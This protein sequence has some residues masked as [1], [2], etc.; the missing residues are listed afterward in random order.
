MTNPDDETVRRLL[1]STRHI[2]VVGLSPNPMRDSH[3]ITA[4]MQRQGYRVTGVNPGHAT[5]LGEPCVPTLADIARLPGDPRPLDLV[6]FFRRSSEVGRHMDEAVALGAR[7]LWLQLGVVDEAAAER[8]RAAGVV[9]VMDLCLMVE[10]RR[11]GVG[12]RS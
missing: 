2:A 3:R 12:R 8:A 1:E 9:V 5:I 7:A 11:L 10:H 4:Y 6:N